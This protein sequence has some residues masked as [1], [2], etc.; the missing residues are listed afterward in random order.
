MLWS[1]LGP[2]S[3]HGLDPGGGRTA[4][5]STLLR[6]PCLKKS[7]QTSEGAMNTWNTLL[8]QKL[9]TKRWLLFKR[10]GYSFHIFSDSASWSSEW[11]FFWFLFF[12]VLGT[13]SACT[14]FLLM[15]Q[16][17][18]IFSLTCPGHKNCASF[19]CKIISK[20]KILCSGQKLFSLQNNKNCQN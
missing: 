4:K 14:F 16:N 1:S 9:N 2:G 8:Y 10:H 17:V 6:H 5:P 15:A 7:C 20:E 19:D 11:L 12:A 18:C 13:Q 3:Q